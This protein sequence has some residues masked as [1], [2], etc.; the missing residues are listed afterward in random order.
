MISVKSSEAT[1]SYLTLPKT[2]NTPSDIHMLQ[3]DFEF[4]SAE[5]KK[6]ASQRKRGK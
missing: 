2:F 4:L 1:E 6:D 5:T 3:K